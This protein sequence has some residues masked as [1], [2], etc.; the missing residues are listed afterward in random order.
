M[1]VGLLGG[2]FDPI[3]SGHLQVA[4]EL[5]RELQLDNVWFIPAAIPW[6]KSGTV[7]ASS[8]DRIEMVKLG[9]ENE[10]RF[11]VCDWEVSSG[12]YSYTIDTLK[13]A[14][15]ETEGED[16]FFVIIGSDVIQRFGEW[17]EFEEILSLSTV[18]VVVRPGFEYGGLSG[19][20]TSFSNKGN[21]V[22][23]EV[24]V[25]D[26]QSREIRMQASN[27]ELLSGLVPEKVEEHIRLK[28][29]YL[30]HNQQGNG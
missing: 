16:E 17:K 15:K 12:G 23:I 10:P 5:I 18:V 13:R 20:I 8:R 21:I 14:R 2:T 25:L 26:I 6:M 1:R 9:T 4:T 7:Q 3:H 27:Q 22:S 28:G 29:L 30:E 24:P 11:H 19:A